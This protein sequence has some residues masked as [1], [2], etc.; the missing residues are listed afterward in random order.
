MFPNSET[1]YNKHRKKYFY[2]QEVKGMTVRERMLALKIK[3]KQDKN[4][5]YAKKIGIQVNIVE[6]D[7]DIKRGV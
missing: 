2:R 3:E 4:P 1:E 5:E 7:R 6:K